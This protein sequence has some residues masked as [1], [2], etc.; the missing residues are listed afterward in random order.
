MVI[1]DCKESD[2]VEIHG[3]VDLRCS[4]SK[5]VAHSVALRMVM[6]LAFSAGVEV[7]FGA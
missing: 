5:G 2:E 4:R 6:C 1:S 3:S 7:D